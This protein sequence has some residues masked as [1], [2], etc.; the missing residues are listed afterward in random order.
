MTRDELLAALEEA[1]DLPDGEKR[2]AELER[3]VR[4]ADALGD[5]RVGLEARFELVE[6]Y[7]HHTERW[8]MLPVVRW[9][10]R[11][12]DR[13]P[14]IFDAWD[15]EVL[16][17][18]HRWAVAA[19]PGTPRIGLIEALAALDDLARRLAAAGRSPRAE[20]QLRCRLADHVGD[21]AGARHWLARWRAAP[22]DGDSG[23]A[24]CDAVRQAELLAEWGDWAE[25]VAAAEPAL[26]GATDCTEQPEFAL[27]AVMLP[28]LH[29]GRHEEAAQAHV[30]AY[31]RHRFERDA[32]G[33]VAR[34]LRFCALSGHHERGL[35]LLETHLGWL[36]R[37]C[38]EAAAMEFA[39]AGALLCRLADEHGHGARR[40]HRPG[41]GARRAADVTAAQLGPALAT[42]ARRVAG[43]FDARNG[44]DHQSRRVAAWL[45]A[46]P[47]CPAI[48][49][50]AEDL[51]PQPA[52]APAAEELP[53]WPD[54]L[55]PLSVAAITAVLS[56]RGDHYV[57]DDDG[58]VVGQWGP[59]L[60]HFERLGARHEI[61]HSRI[62]A[63]R[64]LPFERLPD[65][66]EFCNSWNH[67]K[68]LP[69]AYVHVDRGDLI[70]AGEVS[71][72][73]EHGVTGGQLDVLINSVIGT[74]I[75]FA[76][77][78]EHLP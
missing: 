24:N 73:L 58:V 41:H 27:A 7:Q 22:H 37:P 61:L 21:E 49:L 43:R 69:K 19:V 28:Y 66:L 30:T 54:A 51:E 60:I 44:T 8:R 38:D 47:L 16:R 63:A 10:L 23:C 5:V 64:R 11:A 13:D 40:L 4:H 77:A 32:L 72:D 34:H 31:R 17:R 2:V 48:P 29:L 36:D 70:L 46:E 1:R 25:A 12:Y 52:P 45:A 50:P 39:A 71:T 57:F 3:V 55:A 62:I 56:A 20:H 65:A 18:Q 75:A 53:G 26:G 67:D 6:S 33:L 68:V 9:C 15:V 78:V 59:A 76:T 35:E 74:G 42:A 14:S